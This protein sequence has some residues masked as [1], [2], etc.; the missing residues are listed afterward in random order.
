[1]SKFIWIYEDKLGKSFNLASQQ[2]C[3]TTLHWSLTC[4]RCINQKNGV[5]QFHKRG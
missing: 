5:K 3:S 2:L 4:M 1:V